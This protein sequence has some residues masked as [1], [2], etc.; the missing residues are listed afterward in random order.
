M[1]VYLSQMPTIAVVHSDER[2]LSFEKVLEMVREALGHL[3]GIRAFVKPGQRFLSSP[4]KAYPKRRAR[5][6]TRIQC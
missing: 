2:H 4:S 3:G 6:V 1:A 5:V